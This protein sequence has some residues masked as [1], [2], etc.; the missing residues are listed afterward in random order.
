MGKMLEE[1]LLLFDLGRPLGM[2]IWM[3]HDDFISFIHKFAKITFS[4]ILRFLKVGHNTQNLNQYIFFQI[5]KF[6][7]SDFIIF[8]Y[9]SSF[10]QEILKIHK[11]IILLKFNGKQANL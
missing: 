11:F 8:K 3:H 2:L 5:A 4:E 7:I 9:I 10:I 6:I 1:L